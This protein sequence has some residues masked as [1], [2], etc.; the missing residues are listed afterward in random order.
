MLGSI[1][2]NLLG[3]SLSAGGANTSSDAASA[4]PAE[5]QTAPGSGPLGTVVLVVDD[6]GAVVQREWPL[7]GFAGTPGFFAPEV[8]CEPRYDARQVD[9]WSLGCIA[10]ELI[11]G[12]DLFTEVWM[13]AYEKQ[14]M[15]DR[16]EF[17]AALDRTLALLRRLPWILEAQPPSARATSGRA[18]SGSGRG[19]GS[20]SSGARI[21]SLLKRAN[22]F[23]KD[24]T[25]LQK[26]PETSVSKDP[27]LSEPASAAAAGCLEDGTPLVKDLMFRMLEPRPER[28]AAVASVLHHPWLAA[29]QATASF[30]LPAIVSI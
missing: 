27:T 4:P 6:G 15:A 8:L 9:V 10:L 20:G 14:T 1:A 18:R 7:S 16:P 24:P 19:S 13:A 3:V 28:R 2:S 25:W 30:T 5:C 29:E 17:L 12:H 23:S 11:L 22:S 26:R 21:W